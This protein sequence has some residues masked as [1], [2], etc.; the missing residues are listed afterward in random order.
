[1]VS[2]VKRS[3]LRWLA[4][5]EAS[6]IEN[7]AA[8]ITHVRRT[9][10]RHVACAGTPSPRS[11]PRGGSLGIGGGFLPRRWSGGSVDLDDARTIGQR[12]RWIRKGSVSHWWW[13]LA[14]LG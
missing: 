3:S 10:A 14:L 9:G 13:S 11:T 8:V 4:G 1:M 5:F 6:T 12:L 7:I 2:S